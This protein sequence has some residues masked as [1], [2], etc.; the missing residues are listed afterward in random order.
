MILGVL[1]KDIVDITL[2]SKNIHLKTNAFKIEVPRRYDS[3]LLNCDSR[4]TGISFRRYRHRF[5][6]SSS[7]VRK[8]SDFKVKIVLIEN[9]CHLPTVFLGETEI[10]EEEVSV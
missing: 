8:K 4:P 7:E 3:V 6:R 1:D 9:S 10:V 5:A 2:L